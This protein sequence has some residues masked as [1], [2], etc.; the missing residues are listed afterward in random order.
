MSEAP[1]PTS[2][3]PAGGASAPTPPSAD[4]LGALSELTSRM[5]TMGNDQHEARLRLGEAVHAEISR[6]GTGWDALNGNPAKLGAEA[7]ARAIAS[8]SG[9]AAPASTTPAAE[10]TALHSEV[11]DQDE[12]TVFGATMSTAGLDVRI[13]QSLVADVAGDKRISDAIGRGDAGIEAR[14][15]EV[16]QFF[17]RQPGGMDDL[18]LAVAFGEHLVVKEP[19]LATTWDAAML[20]ENVLFS[21]AAEARRLGFA[22]PTRR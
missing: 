8:Q 20:S 16:R 19:K 15:V 13:V 3:A 14:L 18:R 9:D 11:F 22:A 1:I 10:Y 12:A 2:H 7:E 5:S 17:E 4:Q 21:L 6:G